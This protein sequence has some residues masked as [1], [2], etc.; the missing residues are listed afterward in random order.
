VPTSLLQLTSA[1]AAGDE[2]AIEAFYRDYF[3]WLYQKARRATGRDEAF[4][5]DVVQEAVLRILRCV[6]PVEGERP[7]R[8]WLRL[9]VQSTA[10]D[11]MKSESR[12]ARREAVAAVAG[13]SDRRDAPLEWAEQL[14]WLR[15]QVADLD[16]EIARIV[17]LRFHQS[18]TLAK[19]ARVFG[20]SIGTIDGRLRRAIKHLRGLAREEFDDGL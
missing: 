7:F 11:V 15:D 1:M 9:V 13:G 3:D 20:L 4:C 19:I 16:P 14:L 8:A 18:W 17:D 5:L 6:R 2:K 12:R 10:Y